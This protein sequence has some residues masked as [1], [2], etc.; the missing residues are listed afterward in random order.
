VGESGICKFNKA[1]IFYRKFKTEILLVGFRIW[2]ATSDYFW[3]RD[4]TPLVRSL[5]RRR[6]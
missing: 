5:A 3:A 2:F 6:A 1:I 4:A